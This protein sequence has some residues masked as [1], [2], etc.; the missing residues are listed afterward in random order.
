MS[1]VEGRVN[2]RGSTTHSSPVQAFHSWYD[3]RRRTEAEFLTRRCQGTAWKVP[4]VIHCAGIIS[5][6]T[7]NDFKELSPSSC[8]DSRNYFRSLWLETG[9]KANPRERYVRKCPGRCCWD[10]IGDCIDVIFVKLI[11]K[12]GISVWFVGALCWDGETGRFDNDITIT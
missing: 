12:L 3:C 1:T 8:I 7:Y 6:W 4:T 10:A 5:N 11:S 2:M 9:M